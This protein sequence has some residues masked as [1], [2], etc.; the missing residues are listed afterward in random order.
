MTTPRKGASRARGAAS[1]KAQ[2]KSPSKV[3]QTKQ[4]KALTTKDKV[5]M[6]MKAFKWWEEE[7][8]EGVQWLRLEHNGINFP[9]AYEA[10]GVKMLYDGKP[11][12]LTAA[13]EELATH[14]A[15]VAPDGPQLGNP[16]TAGIFNKNF[17]RDFK[18]VL[19]R[20]HTIQDFRKCDFGPIRAYLERQREEK[21]S[22][23]KAGRRSRARWARCR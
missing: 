8:H 2:A 20:G 7:E 16:K 3:A 14:Y 21:K 10:H 5:G 17:F 23:S 13:Q 22:K 9:P 15:M 11:V 4:L 1:R 19:G 18:A 6:A 12:D